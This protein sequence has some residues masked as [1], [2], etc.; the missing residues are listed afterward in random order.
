MAGFL[1]VSIVIVAVRIYHMPQ[2]C[3]GSASTEPALLE[4]GEIVS[5]LLP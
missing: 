1:H 2:L 4:G 3:A 5:H